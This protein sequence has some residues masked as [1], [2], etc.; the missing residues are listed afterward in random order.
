MAEIVD[1]TPPSEPISLAREMTK[2]T[3]GSVA[4]VSVLVYK[5]GTMWSEC[6]GHHKKDV[7][8]ALQDMI[9]QLMLD[10]RE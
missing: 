8:W 7:L 2:R 6:C 5:D 10:H 1:I 3:P 9:F 4:A